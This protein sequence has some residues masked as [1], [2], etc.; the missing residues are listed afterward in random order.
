MHAARVKSLANGVAGVRMAA[1]VSIH[2]TGQAYAALA[3]ITAKSGVKPI[4]RRLSNTGVD[5]EQPT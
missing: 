1:V 3:G 5:V 2:A 4:D